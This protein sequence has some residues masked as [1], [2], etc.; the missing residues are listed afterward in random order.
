MIGTARRLAVFVA[1]LGCIAAVDVPRGAFGVGVLRRDGVLIPFA[2]FDGKRWRNAWPAP[3]IDLVVPISLGSIPSRWWGP[4][5]PLD[6][7]Q[8]W[9][10]SVARAVRVVQ[11][12]W[13][14]VH[15]ARHIGLRTDYHGEFSPPDTIQPYPKDGLAVS[16]PQPVEPIESIPVAAAALRAMAPT[17][18][19]AFN[20]A[21]RETEARFGHPISRR[22]R[23]TIEPAIEA[24]YAFGDSPRVYYI[25]AVR[26]Y[27]EIGRDCTAIS[28]GTGWFTSTGSETKP[29]LMAV[30]ILNCDRRG[31][32]YMLPLGAL[33]IGTRVFW[34]AQ[35]SGWDHERYAIVEITR[36][37]AEAVVS[38]W[39][40]GC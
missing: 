30:D 3:E 15:C 28:V 2:T 8:A 20:Q 32:S 38:T 33:R 40:G 34:I 26:F 31:A 13:V 39:G 19:E 17:L 18:L 14:N 9:L 12:D 25:E 1:L 35:F 37:A 6:R 22:A 23:E 4:T 21:E 10:G 29:L 7:W 16:P 36:K 27:R 24:A 5:G 11:P